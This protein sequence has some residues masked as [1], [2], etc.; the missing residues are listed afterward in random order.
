MRA[1]YTYMAL[2]NKYAPLLNAEAWGVTDLFANYPIVGDIPTRIRNINSFITTMKETNPNVNIHLWALWSR[3]T[4]TN[5]ILSPEN[6]EHKELVMRNIEEIMINCDFDGVT[7]DDPI[8][9]STYYD[10]VKGDPKRL[11]E[12]SDSLTQW[13][14]DFVT[15]IHGV[16]DIPVS[17]NTP[18]YDAPNDQTGGLISVKDVN[19]C[20][21]YVTVG[22]TRYPSKKGY[23]FNFIKDEYKNYLESGN[24]LGKKIVVEILSFDRY[25]KE[26]KPYNELDKE[27]KLIL[28]LNPCGYAVCFYEYF[29]PGYVFPDSYR[30][31]VRRRNVVGVRQNNFTRLVRS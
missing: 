14:D 25:T 30:K 19:E 26:V 28:G 24:H 6:G 18:R 4:G 20:F 3:E 1:L 17:G 23:D 13:I 12:L 22:L 31:I 8:V 16:R 11:N 29:V 21:D 10:Q 27:L 7:M 5:K 15:T 9:T 2:T